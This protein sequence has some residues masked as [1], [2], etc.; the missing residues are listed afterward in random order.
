MSRAGEMIIGH[1]TNWKPEDM[2]SLADCPYDMNDIGVWIANGSFRTDGMTIA[3]CGTKS[4]PALAN[5][6]V[7]NSSPGC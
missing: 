2:N 5:S 1:E 7:D 4:L 3:P 6:Y